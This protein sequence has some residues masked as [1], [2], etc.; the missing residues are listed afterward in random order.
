M[1]SCAFADSSFYSIF[2]AP[3]GFNGTLEFLHL[4]KVSMD[5]QKSNMDIVIARIYELDTFYV[6]RYRSGE[7]RISYQTQIGTYSKTGIGH[8]R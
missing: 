7:G 1:C 8:L 4:F 2:F 5:F 6:Q 3:V